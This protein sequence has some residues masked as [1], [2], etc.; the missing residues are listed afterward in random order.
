[1]AKKIIGLLED[2]EKCK[3]MGEFGHNRVVNELAWDHTSKA[4]LDEY[5]RFFNGDF[6]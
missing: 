4:L 6:N 2:P 3:K 5:E 1:M